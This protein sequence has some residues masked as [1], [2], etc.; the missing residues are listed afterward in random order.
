MGVLR[1]ISKLLA[2]DLGVDLGTANTI[3]CTL[4]DGIVL[5]EPSVVA[6]NSK[7]NEVLLDGEA[8]GEV[9]KNMV[10][11][12]HPNLEIIRPLKE[13]VITNFDATQKML[14]YFMYTVQRFRLG[15]RPLTVISIPLGV[16]DP[17]R[18]AVKN[19]AEKAG[20]SEVLIVPQPFAAA[21]GSGL[22]VSQ[23]VGSMI[24]DI[25]GGTTDIAVVSL[26]GI[27]TSKTLR[28]A[29]DTMDEAI[30][31]FV[32]NEYG[33]LIGK[34]TA[35]YIKILIGSVW[36][37]DEVLPYV[38]HG[39]DV[40]TNMPKAI[41]VTSEL[42]RPAFNEIMDTIIDGIIDVIKNSP[43]DLAEDLIEKG[44][45][46]AG[47]GAMLRGIDMIIESRV[48]LPVQICE[49]PLLAVA[50]GTMIVLENPNYYRDIINLE[51]SAA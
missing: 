50:F 29:G 12:A 51:S 13:G 27:V 45:T 2:T 10:G 15:V 25:G 41:M 16:T 26:N 39:R 33:L 46:L 5:M 31:N 6:M 19:S 9:A 32:C 28:I 36:Q 30:Q 21:L 20:A 22:P 18:K 17:E 48:E 38:I 49:Y 37:I 11:K 3:V 23:P 40:Q 47:G 8:V 14:E 34:Q 1:S 4:K 35:E 44:I 7:T 43:A 24:V 42:I